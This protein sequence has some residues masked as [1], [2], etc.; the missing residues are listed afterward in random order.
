MKKELLNKLNTIPRGTIIALNGKQY[1]KDIETGSS[2][3]YWFSMSEDI[4]LT[5]E[6]VVK[7]ILNK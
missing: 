1:V 3:T 4:K 2:K 7:I 6:E 5:N